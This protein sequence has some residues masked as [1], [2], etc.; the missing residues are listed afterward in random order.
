M[1]YPLSL[2]LEGRKCLVVGGG[3]VAARKTGGLLGA[4]A[5]VL[6][7]SPALCEE[8]KKLKDEKKISH[9]ERAF[10]AEDAFGMALVFAATDDEAVNASVA[11]AARRHGA[12]ANV[13]SQPDG[14]DFLVPAVFREG[15]L[16]VAV[17]T[18][19]ASP[20][21]AVWVRDELKAALPPGTLELVAVFK[22]LRAEFGQGAGSGPWKALLDEGLAGDLAGGNLLLAAQKIDARFGEGVFA[23][24]K[25]GLGY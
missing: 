5:A 11:E 14:G 3:R 16:T 20:A 1:S 7:V 2:N 18:G 8:L 15:G 21:A 4:G 9:E 10:K 25:K 22:A 24:L 13:A 19:G 23:R 6:V 12:L 17:D